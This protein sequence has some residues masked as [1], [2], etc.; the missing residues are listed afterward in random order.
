MPQFAYRANEDVTYE[1][2]EGKTRVIKAG[3]V[4]DD[5]MV[6]DSNQASFDIVDTGGTKANPASPTD[7]SGD[8]AV[9]TDVNAE[10]NGENG[11]EE[12]EEDLAARSQR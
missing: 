9:G 1:D 4:V 2:A 11:E 7:R 6:Y 5:E 12:E 10:S 8:E 3:E